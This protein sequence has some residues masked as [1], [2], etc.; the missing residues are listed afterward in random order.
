MGNAAFS[1][2]ILKAP[3]A[4]T[5]ANMR[6]SS[7]DGTAFVDFSAS[8]FSADNIRNNDFV[9]IFDSAKRKI[10]GFIK[11]AGTGETFSDELVLNGNDWTGASG[12][13]PTTGWNY[14][15]EAYRGLYDITAGGQSGDCIKIT[16]DDA[17]VGYPIM[18][19]NALATAGALYVTSLYAQKGTADYADVSPQG[20][21]VPYISNT[22]W[23]TQKLYYKTALAANLII[24]R[25]RAGAQNQYALFDTVSVKQILTP[26]STGV[27]ITNTPG[28]ST[29]NWGVKDANFNYNDSSGYTY[30]I[31][32]RQAYGTLILNQAIVSGTLHLDIAD[33]SAMFFHDSID[34]STYAGD[35]A[36]VTLYEMVF[37]DVAGKCAMAY[38]AAQGGG[39]S[40]DNELSADQWVNDDRAG[41]DFETLDDT[42]GRNITRATNTSGTGLA[43]NGANRN[44]SSYLSFTIGAI[45]KLGFDYTLYSGTSAGIV[46]TSGNY[47]SGNSHSWYADGALTTGTYAKYKTI[48]YTSLNILTGIGVAS[49]FKWA[50]FTLKKMLDIPTTGLHLVSAVGGTTRNMK[51]VD[52][53]FDPNTV[54]KVRVYRTGQTQ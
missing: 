7:V 17:G 22:D 33:G 50:S 53:G 41:N 15:I 31:I 18:Q 27:T 19:T 11:A 35:D 37:E 49:D 21:V 29:Y 12:G 26:S 34:W 2:P 24:L 4:V 52:S 5:Q 36:G 1:N 14:N 3:T 38:A 8:A 47:G 25:T 46:S 9:E 28:G 6:I 40:F 20:I 43:Y 32:S 42:G 44:G 30:R 51:S 39:E 16:N 48:A 45:Y 54:T 10:G 23:N 13:T